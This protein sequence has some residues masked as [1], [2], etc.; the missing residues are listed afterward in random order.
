MEEITASAM[1]LSQMAEELHQL[2]E[3]FRVHQAIEEVQDSQ[4]QT[5]TT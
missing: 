3:A 4:N 2:V 5:Q 1:S